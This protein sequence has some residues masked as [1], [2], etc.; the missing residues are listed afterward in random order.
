MN[1]KII[2]IILIVV[3]AAV[4]IFLLNNSKSSANYASISIKPKLSFDRYSDSNFVN[5]RV[6][7]IAESKGRYYICEEGSK[8]IVVLDENFKY[9]NRIGKEGSGPGEFLAPWTCEVN[10]DSLYV[11]DAEKNSNNDI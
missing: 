3:S 10:K 6:K 1:G 11:L 7:S 2:V 5:N 8:G 4:G 9:L